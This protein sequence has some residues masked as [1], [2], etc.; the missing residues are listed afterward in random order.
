VIGM[1][2]SDRPDPK[3]ILQSTANALGGLFAGVK[4][5]LANVMEKSATRGEAD[6]PATEPAATEPAAPEPAAA[7]AAPAPPA[8]LARPMGGHGRPAT[9]DHVVLRA[10]EG[11][12]TKANVVLARKGVKDAKV[13]G[14][15][16]E[17]RM[18]TNRVSQTLKAMIEAHIEIMGLERTTEAAPAHAAAAEPPAG[19]PP[20]PDDPPPPAQG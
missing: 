3:K 1:A 11:Q 5:K 16:L 20:A 13:D 14:D 12:G 18:A 7:D 2:E 15:R 17:F 8:A 9:L 6:A 19:A 4:T 10:A